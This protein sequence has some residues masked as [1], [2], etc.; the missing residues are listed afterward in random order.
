[1]RLRSCVPIMEACPSAIRPR[2]LPR[3]GVV[4]TLV[5]LG[6]A[7]IPLWWATDETETGNRLFLL[8]LG[9]LLLALAI[10]RGAST[11][12]AAA[13]GRTSASE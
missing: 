5:L 6:L 11:A 12:R 9:A 7:V 10:W 3:K 8:G 13:R 4:G 1:M 2:R